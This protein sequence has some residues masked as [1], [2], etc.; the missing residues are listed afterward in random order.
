MG[1]PEKIQKAILA[2]KPFTTAQTCGYLTKG[3]TY[4]LASPPI[5]N[6]DDKWHDLIAITTAGT[7]RTL[8]WSADPRPVLLLLAEHDA[9]ESGAF[10]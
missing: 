4:I 10:L 1:Y 9:F 7:V 3:G 2:R 5:A 6:D 8:R